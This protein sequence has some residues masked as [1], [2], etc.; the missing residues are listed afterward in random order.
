MRWIGVFFLCFCPSLLV[1]KL[2]VSLSVPY[3]YVVD[4]GSGR[5]LYEKNSEE[6]IYPASTT[7]IATALYVLSKVQNLDEVIPCASRHAI[8]RIS[9]KKKVSNHFTDA[10]YLLEYDGVLF[11]LK[12]GEELSLRD[13]LFILMLASAN[14]VANVL[15]EYVSGDIETFCLEL[16]E[17]VQGLGCERTHFMNP[18]G[19]HHPEHVSTPKDMVRLGLCA[20]EHPILK[21]IISTE[22][23][24]VAETNKSKAKD[25]VQGNKLLK[26]GQFYYPN[27]IGVKTGSHL[28]AGKCLV[29]AAENGSRSILGGF[30]KAKD[31]RNL[32]GDAITLF[33]AS[34]R[35]K[36]VTRFLFRANEASFFTHVKKEKVRADL[37][38]D[39]SIQYY[40]SEDLDLSTALVWHGVSL[41]IEKGDVIGALRIYEGDV[42][43]EEVPLHAHKEY[44]L[45]RKPYVWGIV[46]LAA[47][48]AFGWFGLQRRA[49]QTGAA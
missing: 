1:A 48:I 41:P 34:F 24:T 27:A 43:L 6:L 19:L 11:G 17:F 13:M 44:L 10:P 40:P 16:N 15:A 12:H 14:D 2:H 42:L 7:K 3:A 31:W 45:P 35:E 38:E 23:Y 22:K 29:A 37:L 25:I 4:A 33:D 32:Y 39:V 49:Q 36:P 5:V 21:A 20:L 30:F 28:R 26:P 9:P 8:A 46:L 18:H 47:L